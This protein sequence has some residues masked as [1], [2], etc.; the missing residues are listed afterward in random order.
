M[1]VVLMGRGRG[2]GS[3][4]QVMM[5]RARVECW[6]NTLSI[7]PQPPQVPTRVHNTSSSIEG[8]P[9]NVDQPDACGSRRHYHD[10]RVHS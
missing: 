9:A 4:Y 1:E 7:P 2:F 10:S 6:L 5:F 8:L 3:G